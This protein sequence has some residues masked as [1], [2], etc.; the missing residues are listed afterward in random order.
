LLQVPPLQALPHPA[1][2][3]LPLS[4][5]LLQVAPLQQSL[6]LSLHLQ[7]VHGHE[8]QQHFWVV[9]AARTKVGVVRVAKVR[10]ASRLRP[11]RN[12]FIVFILFDSMR[13]F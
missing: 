5:H 11:V 12:L 2:P 1:L 8:A 6:Q 4:Q 7:F 9:S 10:P 13:T 3:H